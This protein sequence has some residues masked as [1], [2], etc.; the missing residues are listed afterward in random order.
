MSSSP[1][2]IT[3][4]I[5]SYSY[6]YSYVYVYI[7]VVAGRQRS[8]LLPSQI[9]ICLAQRKYRHL[10]PSTEPYRVSPKKTS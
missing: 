1:M 6:I 10:Y 3:S 4:V 5:R 9:Q 8:P 2:A 7:L